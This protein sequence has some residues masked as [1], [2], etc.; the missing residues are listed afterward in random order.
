MSLRLHFVSVLIAKCW[1]ARVFWSLI[2]YWKVGNLQIQKLGSGRIQIH[3]R[4]WDVGSGRI[5]TGST[6]ATGY[7]AGSGSGSG[8]PL[9]VMLR[10][11]PSSWTDHFG[12]QI[13]YSNILLVKSYSWFCFSSFR[14]FL[15][16]FNP[17]KCNILSISR[18]NPLHTFYSLCG[19]VLQNVH[20]ARY[21]GINSSE[22]L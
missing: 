17:G 2:Y 22:D 12:N 3:P 16:Q 6:K 18:S 20:E 8:A 9:S 21:L 15:I 4:S 5:R 19:T 11:R 1:Q 14:Y 13:Q 10:D 7:P